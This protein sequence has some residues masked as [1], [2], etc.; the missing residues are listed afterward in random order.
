MKLEISDLVIMTKEYI[1]KEHLM[2]QECIFRLEGTRM[3]IYRK[4]T[5]QGLYVEEFLIMI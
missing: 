2:E 3:L 1:R 4:H 5:I